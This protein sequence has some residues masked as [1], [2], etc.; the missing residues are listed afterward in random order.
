M[1]ILHADVRHQ[2][3]LPVNLRQLIWWIF[4]TSLHFS[5]MHHRHLISQLFYSR[6][7]LHSFPFKLCYLFFLLLHLLERCFQID[8]RWHWKRQRGW[9]STGEQKLHLYPTSRFLLVVFPLDFLYIAT[10][11]GIIYKVEWKKFQGEKFIKKENWI[12][13]YG[14]IFFAIFPSNFWSLTSS[15]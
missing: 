12:I 10:P 15:E 6:F 2:F 7:I 9:K 11:S 1:F 4:V 8:I 14:K 13:V 5:P 3:L